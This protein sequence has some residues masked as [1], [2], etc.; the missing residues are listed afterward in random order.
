MGK[1]APKIHRYSWSKGTTNVRGSTKAYRI[2][3]VNYALGMDIGMLV[4]NLLVIAY[5]NGF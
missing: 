1:G 2:L 5:S 4:P 3:L